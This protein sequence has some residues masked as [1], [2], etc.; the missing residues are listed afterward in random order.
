MDFG[1]VS[2]AGS[3]CTKAASTTCRSS[4][5][6]DGSFIARIAYVVACPVLVLCLP[7]AT[8][9]GGVFRAS[10]RSASLFAGR[11]PSSRLRL[12][13][14]FERLRHHFAVRFFQ[15]NFD[16]SLSLFQLLLAFPGKRH[17]FFKQLHR[18]VQ[19]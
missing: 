9:G 12:A 8:R 15:Q 19:R 11:P 18:L 5:K 4:S 14:R 3:S 7:R 2:A 13:F 1:A 17:A 10:R 6:K 16:S